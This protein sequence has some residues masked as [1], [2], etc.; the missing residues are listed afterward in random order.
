[1]DWQD[2]INKAKCDIILVWPD[3]TNQ[4]VKTMQDE[5][6][7]VL[8]EDYKIP[9]YP[10]I[11]E[12]WLYENK[13]VQQYWL[14]SN[15]FPIAKTW[16][17]YEIAET[18]EFLKNSNYPLVFKSNLGAS[19]SGVY[20]VKNKTEAIKKAKQFISKGYKIKGSKSSVSQKGSL[21]IQ[22]FISNAKEWRMVRIGNSYFGHGKD[23][24]GQFH[25][26]SGKANYEIPPIGAFELLKLIT[27]RGNFTSM[28]VDIFED[29]NGNLYVNELQTMFGT[30]I[31]KEQ[32]KKNGVPGRY[33]IK[34]K[35]EFQFEA[36]NFC[37][38][39]LCNLR[40]QYLLDNL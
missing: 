20:I 23:M 3:I 28:D 2:Q 39:H 33:L 1:M 10:S 12:I 35:G 24:K 34:K 38:N 21:Y 16:V 6:L 5:R 27:D 40:L 26:G 31:A 11:K 19:A 25:S 14:K 30:S 17:F 29:S 9:I 36:G 15:N 7:R 22:E 13:R 8:V 37:E 4:I 18:V 32:M